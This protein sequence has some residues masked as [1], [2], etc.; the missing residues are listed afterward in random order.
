MRARLEKAF[1]RM[2]DVSVL[3]DEAAA[4][5]IRDA[6]ID[7]LVNLNGYFGRPRM[8][9]F[10]RRAAPVQV[11]YLGFPATLGASYIDYILADGIVIPQA[12]HPFYDEKVVTLPGSYQVND[13]K[14]RTIAK[15]PSRDEAGLPE[16]AFV[17]AIFNYSY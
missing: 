17:F 5:A 4:A 15:A 9:V 3:S 11:N 8:G 7:I 16:D 6:E 12:E 13:N 14:G 10:A 2:I 1:D